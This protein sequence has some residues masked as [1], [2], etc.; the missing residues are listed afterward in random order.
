MKWAIG[1]IFG[2]VFFYYGVPFLFQAMKKH[3]YDALYH[4]IQDA[5][6]QAGAYV[7]EDNQKR[8]KSYTKRY[9][10]GEK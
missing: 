10:Q 8:F 2:F 9:L 5:K 1:L 7:K 6:R 4:G 3:D